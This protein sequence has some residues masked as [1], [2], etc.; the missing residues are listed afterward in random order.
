MWFCWVP[1]DP[2]IMSIFIFYYVVHIPCSGD[3]CGDIQKETDHAI[4]FALS[5]LLCQGFIALF[6]VKWCCFFLVYVS[7]QVCTCECAYACVVNFEL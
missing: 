4:A 7:M 3:M 1:S 5:F 2:G 6:R